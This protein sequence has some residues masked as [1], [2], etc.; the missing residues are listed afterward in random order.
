MMKK[1]NNGRTETENRSNERENNDA[2]QIELLDKVGDTT[3]ITTN[4]HIVLNCYGNEDLTHISNNFKMELP[5]LM[6]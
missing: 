6:P 4:Q 3:D 2:K 1:I 5:H